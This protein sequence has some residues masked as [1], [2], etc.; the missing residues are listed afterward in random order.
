[1]L[2]VPASQELIAPP[3]PRGRTRPTPQA[4]PHGE[5]TS[6]RSDDQERKHMSRLI[7]SFLASLDGYIA[8]DAGGFEWAVPNEEVLD[9]I[10]AAER[11]VGTYLYGRTMYEMMV[12]WENDPARRGSPPRARSSLRSGRRRRR[13]SSRAAC[14]RCPRSAPGSSATSIQ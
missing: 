5:G 6:Q 9:F 7:Y 13:S 14:S 12:G 1:M 3:Q 10:S 8:D 11:E 2:V 4:V